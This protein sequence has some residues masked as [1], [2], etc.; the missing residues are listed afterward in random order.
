MTEEGATEAPPRCGFVALLGAPNAGKST[1]LNALIGAK[2]SIVT[3]KV[4]TTRIRIRGIALEG[5]CQIVFVDTPGIFTPK[6]RLERSMVAAAWSGAQD[7]DVR[8]LLYDAAQRRIDADTRLILDGLKSR[9][10]TA[11]LALNKVDI[12]KRQRLLEIA[13]GF[14][15]EGLFS[16]IFM[17]SA[18]TGDG[19]ADLRA[20]LAGLMPEGPWLYPEDQLS[21][22]PERL[23]AAEVTRE[24]LFLR[25]HQELPYA[26]TVETEDWQ[27]FEDGAVRIEQIVYVAR[28]T[29]KGICLGKGG[30]TIKAVREAAQADLETLLE[31]KVH[32]FLFVKV[33]EK[34]L[35]D[36][37]RYRALGLEF[38]V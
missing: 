21:D 24:K 7:A 27:D 4:Q 30:A 23:L 14:E 22:L 28:E 15:A 1:L 29:H 26:L 19:V 35:D 12:M 31:R 11:M 20:Q 3:H 10:L 36:P 18:L 9:G 16:G 17:I 32:L 34:W 5:P 33:R 6:R 2:V 37:E 38:E 13:A 25:L 8:V